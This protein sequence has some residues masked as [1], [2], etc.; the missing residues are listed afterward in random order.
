LVNDDVSS[1]TKQA[2][3]N[4]KNI[5][6]EG[7]SDLS[8]VV[9]TTVLLKHID[10]YAAVNAVYSQYFPI[11]PPARAAYAVAALPAGALVEIDAIAVS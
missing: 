3:E 10:D 7:G 1:Q 8:K 2:L 5:L 6:L 11:N 4:L 9:K